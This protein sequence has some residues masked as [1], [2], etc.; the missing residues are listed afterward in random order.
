MSSQASA[1]NPCTMANPSNELSFADICS[2][3]DELETFR[4]KYRARGNGI[5]RSEFS[6]NKH[7]KIDEWIRDNKPV[8]MK[9][10]HSILATLSLLFPHLQA[11]RTY[12]M[13]EHALAKVVSRVLGMGPRGEKELRNWKLKDGNFG[14][15]MERVMKDRVTLLLN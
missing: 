15:A 4:N 3:L 5:K 11:D 13:Q 7:S 2:L 6:D 1:E 14:V 12:T 10:S 9:D 8:I